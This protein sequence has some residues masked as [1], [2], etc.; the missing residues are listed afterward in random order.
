MYQNEWEEMTRMFRENES[1]SKCEKE[2][3]SV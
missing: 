1:K 2:C 3:A